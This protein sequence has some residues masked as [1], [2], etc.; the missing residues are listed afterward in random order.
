MPAKCSQVSLS[1]DAQLNSWVRILLRLDR[2]L[3]LLGKVI[4][5]SDPV[6]PS[7]EITRYTVL[8]ESRWDVASAHAPIMLSALCLPLGGFESKSLVHRRGSFRESISEDY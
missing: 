8:I 1:L 5:D 4:R 2:I 7:K 3:E 6:T